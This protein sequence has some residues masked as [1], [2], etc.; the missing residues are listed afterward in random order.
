[1][2]GS[3][4][5]FEADSIEEVRKV[6]ESDI[7]YTSNVVRPCFLWFH[8]PIYLTLSPSG[9]RKKSVF[10][11]LCRR[12]PNLRIRPYGMA[13]TVIFVESMSTPE[14]SISSFSSL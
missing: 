4:V 12:G 8:R 3:L 9:T 13:A 10:Y 11:H 6:V 7:Y 14:I 1:M 2:V 5:F